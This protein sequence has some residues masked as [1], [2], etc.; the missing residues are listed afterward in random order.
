GFQKEFPPMSATTIK[1]RLFLLMSL[2]LI[3]LLISSASLVRSAYQGYQSAN[4]TQVALDTAAAAGALVHALQVERG[5]TVGFLQSRGQKF[6]DSLPAM[7][8]KTDTAQA[9]F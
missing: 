3:A 1:Q 2:P 8:G 7:R 5:M 4:R 9:S 6:A